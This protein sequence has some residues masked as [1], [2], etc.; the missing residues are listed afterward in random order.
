MDRLMLD[1]WDCSQDGGAE[2]QGVRGDE[3]AA[4]VATSGG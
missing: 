2:G 1:R 3:G 4:E